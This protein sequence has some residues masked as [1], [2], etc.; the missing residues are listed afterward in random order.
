MSYDEV[1]SLHEIIEQGIK[2]YVNGLV[3]TNGIESF[4]RI[5]RESLLA[6]SSWRVRYWISRSRV[7][8]DPRTPMI[9]WHRLCKGPSVCGA[10]VHYVDRDE[11][12]ASTQDALSNKV[13]MTS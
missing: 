4:G 10:Q 11:A 13:R 5:N 9:R 1:G 7:I 2:D 12:R 8:R 6:G 3:Y